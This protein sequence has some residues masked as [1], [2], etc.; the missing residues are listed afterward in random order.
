[1]LH[2]GQ[3]LGAPLRSACRLGLAALF[4]TQ[5]P[6]F[7]GSGVLAVGLTL[8]QFGVTRGHVH[9]EFREL[10]KVSGTFAFWHGFSMPDFGGRFYVRK[11]NFCAFSSGTA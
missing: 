3:F 6:E 7:N 2:V 1:M 5:F 8:G 10:I 11:T 4:P 9:N